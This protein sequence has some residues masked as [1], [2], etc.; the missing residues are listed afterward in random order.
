MEQTFT[1]VKTRTDDAHCGRF[2]SIKCETWTN[3]AQCTDMKVA[4]TDDSGYMLVHGK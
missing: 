1:V 2:V 3:V 4:G